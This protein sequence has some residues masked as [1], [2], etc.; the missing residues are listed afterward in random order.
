MKGLAVSLFIVLAPQVALAQPAEAP[1]DVPP[2]AAAPAYTP[3]TKIAEPEGSQTDPTATVRWF[4][5]LRIEEELPPYSARLQKLFEA[6]LANSKKL[7]APVAGLDFAFQVNAQDTEPGY[8][9][10]LRFSPRR[11]DGKRTRVRV[12][13]RN[14]RQVELIYDLVF[15]NGRWVVDDV[16]STREPRW[17]LSR[18]YMTGAKEK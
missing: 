9:K 15:E 2:T 6:A 4:Y 3:P 10:T 18:L 7:D 8:E 14:F 16:R 17:V 11:T 1:K 12:T 13:L 5:P